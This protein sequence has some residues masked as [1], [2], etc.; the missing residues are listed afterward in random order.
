MPMFDFQCQK[1]GRQFEELVRRGE[2]PACPQCQ[3]ASVEKLLSAPAGHV[4]GGGGRSLPVMGQCS[5]PPG[6]HTC[7][8]GCRHG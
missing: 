4:A 5:P 7:G 1:C 3:S 2:T 6:Q 8:S